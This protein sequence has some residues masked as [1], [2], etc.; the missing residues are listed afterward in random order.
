VSFAIEGEWAYVR[1]EITDP[2][3]ESPRQASEYGM[4]VG[5]NMIRLMAGSQWA[6]V[7]VQFAYPAPADV[8]EH[9][10]VQ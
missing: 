6:P 1:H 5:R 4:A 9:T 7:E 8:A 2:S 3:I 10:R